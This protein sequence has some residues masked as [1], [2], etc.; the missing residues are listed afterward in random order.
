MHVLFRHPNDPPRLARRAISHPTAQSGIFT[1]PSSSPSSFPN[2]CEVRSASASIS[3]FA[4]FSDLCCAFKP[5]QPQRVSGPTATFLPVAFKLPS[6]Q[7][8][9]F[10][11][12]KDHRLPCQPSAR[13]NVVLIYT[14]TASDC[15]EMLVEFADLLGSGVRIQLTPPY[16][17]QQKP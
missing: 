14:R 17:R 12:W 6:R 9:C 11:H 15:L 7:V 1:A 13:R 4:S 8:V 16:H 2:A 10:G 5:C 3:S